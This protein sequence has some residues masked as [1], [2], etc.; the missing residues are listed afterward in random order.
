VR[1][2]AKKLQVDGSPVPVLEGVLRGNTASPLSSAAQ[3]SFSNTGSL[4]FVP[5]PA[6]T[7]AWVPLPARTLALADRNGKLQ[8]LGIPPQPIYHPRISPRGNQLV[9]G[10]DDGKEGIIWIYDMKGNGPPQHLTFGGS[11]RN[12]IWSRDGRYITFASDREGDRGLFRQLADG[13]ALAERLTKGDLGPEQRPEDWNRDDKTLSFIMNHP[14]GPDS[15]IFTLSVE[16]ERKV[17]PLIQ[18][19]SNQRYSVFSPDGD[20]LAYTAAGSGNRFNVF[21]VRFPPTG[22]THQITT[23]G[24]RDPVWSPDGKQLFY[25]TQPDNTKEGHLFSVD[26]RVQA[27]FTVGKPTPI[28]IPGAIL[29]GAGRNYDITPDGKFVVVVPAPNAQGEQ[30]TN[31]APQQ[32]NV[33]LNWFTELQQRVPAK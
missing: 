6:G 10:T 8:S 16:G 1:F 30:Q 17:Q 25:N 33:V 12:P 5:G 27:P 23:S 2:D 15:D 20:W 4:V 3:F 31:R 26:V 7:L 22:E 13:T 29:G 11:N 9:F 21:V 18:S 32:I 24:G 19:P 14:N 28:P